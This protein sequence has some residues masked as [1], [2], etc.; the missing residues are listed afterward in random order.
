MKHTL[1]IS[2]ALAVVS[3]ECHALN[4]IVQ[5]ICTADPAPMIYNDTLYL[6]TGHDEDGSK[7]YVMKDWRCY[8][9]TDM[10]NWTDHGS[11]LS[12]KDFTWVKSDAW[13][14]QC[15][16]RNGNFL[17]RSDDPKQWRRGHRLVTTGSLSLWRRGGPAIEDGRQTQDPVASPH[18]RQDHRDQTGNPHVRHQT[19][20]PGVAP[21]L[22]WA[23]RRDDNRQHESF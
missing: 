16:E 7:R 17:L 20:Q 22:L 6:Y 1:L 3:F 15:F 9:T 23:F 14:G 4:P 10:V 19:D 18:H 12:L 13:A 11:P 5:T 21:V 2:A 8:S